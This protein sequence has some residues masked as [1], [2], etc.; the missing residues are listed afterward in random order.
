MKEH[1]LVAQDTSRYG[2]DFGGGSKLAELMQKAAKIDGVD[3]LR[4]L[5]CYPEETSEQLLDIIANTPNI[6]SYVD[7][8]FST[9]T[10]QC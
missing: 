9:S 2:M 1:I 3:W 7:C 10:T 8:R 5:Y 6:C 4:V